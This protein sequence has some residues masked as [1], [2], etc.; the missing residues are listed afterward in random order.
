MKNFDNNSIPA[1]ILVGCLILG[2]FYY[3]SQT[4]KQESIQT[5]QKRDD[6]RQDLLMNQNECKSLSV[7]V[8]KKWNNVMG[9]T[10]SELWGECEVTY[11]D[12]KTG[13]VRTSLLSSME[14]A[15]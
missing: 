2:G 11:T 10:Y 12:N 5:Q 14:D 3:L 6:E 9:V 15:D 1:A 8:M 7:G 4:S 13:Q